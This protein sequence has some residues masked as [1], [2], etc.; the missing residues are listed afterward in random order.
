MGIRLKRS[1]GE[2]EESAE[3]KDEYVKEEWPKEE[4]WKESSVKKEW[5]EPGLH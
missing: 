3:V 4:E 2:K 1:L 5:G